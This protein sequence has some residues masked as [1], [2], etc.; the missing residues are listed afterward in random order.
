MLALMTLGSAS[1]D[2]TLDVIYHLKGVIWRGDSVISGIPETLDHLRSLVRAGRG[3][4]CLES[5]GKDC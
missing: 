4:E 1:I 5:C 2:T 3:V